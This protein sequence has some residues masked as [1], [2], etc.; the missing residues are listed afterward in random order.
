MMYTRDK[1]DAEKKRVGAFV[2]N[3]FD[4][5]LPANDIQKIASYKESG[6]TI[7]TVIGSCVVLRKY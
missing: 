1:I 3:N 5:I 7:V 4:V 6:W 2:T